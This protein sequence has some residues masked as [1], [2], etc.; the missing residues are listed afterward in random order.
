MPAPRITSA[1]RFANTYPEVAAAVAAKLAEADLSATDYVF[2]SA[3]GENDT[4]HAFYMPA[5]IVAARRNGN[6]DV[7]YYTWVHAEATLPGSG[8][9]T[10]LT[11]EL[12]V[13]GGLPASSAQH[14]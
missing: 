14:R 6:Y 3:V 4:L 13:D 10:N 7:P 2:E 1:T 11:V 8:P 9:V 5:D 12:L